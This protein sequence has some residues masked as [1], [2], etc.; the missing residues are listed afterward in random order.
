MLR[1]ARLSFGILLLAL[2]VMGVFFSFLAIV[3][4]VGAQLA[5]DHNPFATPPSAAQSLLVMGGYVLVAALGSWL[6][7]NKRR[8]YGNG[9]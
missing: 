9:G 3:D 8:E 2:G 6:L 7:F 4:P 5:A 1:F